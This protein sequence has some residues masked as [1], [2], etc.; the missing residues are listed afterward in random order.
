M[1]RV[2]SQRLGHRQLDARGCET[3]ALLGAVE[4]EP[5]RNPVVHFH[6][7]KWR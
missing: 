7:R 1:W 6:L 3:S 2:V 5:T 4:A